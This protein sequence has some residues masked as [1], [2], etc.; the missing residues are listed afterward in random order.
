MTTADIRVDDM[1]CGGCENTLAAA[2]KRVD[3][4]TE[5]S[6]DHKT[7][8]V[9]VLFDS[10]RVDEEQLREQ[11]VVCGYNPPTSDGDE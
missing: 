6:A 8:R 3:G 11:I 1:H 4:V 5:V 9:R 7:G 2:L 10:A